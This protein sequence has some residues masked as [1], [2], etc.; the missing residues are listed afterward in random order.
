MFIDQIQC[1]QCG[2]FRHTKYECAS[3]SR[4]SNRNHKAEIGPIRAIETTIAG[5]A[6][7]ETIEIRTGI[8][9]DMMTRVIENGTDT[10][11]TNVVIA[12]EIADIY[13]TTAQTPRIAIEIVD[14]RTDRFTGSPARLTL[15]GLLRPP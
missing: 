5:I 1:L 10:E 8:R 7:V 15:S 11:M 12:I 6:I 9:A 2:G 13:E 3:K 4:S 14:A